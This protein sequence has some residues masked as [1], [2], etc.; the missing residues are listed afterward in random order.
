MLKYNAFPSNEEK[1]TVSKV[2]VEYTVEGDAESADESQTIRLES[3]DA[4]DGPYI[5]MTLVEGSRFTVCSSNEITE[6]FKDFEERLNY[7]G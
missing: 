5:G 4:G 2:I 1:A 7:R 3:L 6:I